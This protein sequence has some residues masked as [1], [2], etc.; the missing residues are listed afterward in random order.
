MRCWLVILVSLIVSFSAM[1]RDTLTLG[2]ED[3]AA[4][5]KQEFAEQGLGEDVELEFFGGQTSF[6]LRDVDHAKIMISGLDISEGQNKFTA[7]AE[8][9]ADGKSAGQAR[10]LGRYFVM[11]EAWLPL[12]DIEKDAV[13]TADD[14]VRTSL[15]SNRIRDDMIV[16]EE[17]LVGKQAVRTI[18]ANKPI[19]R[20][21][22][23]EEVIVKK[24][25]TVMVVYQNKG[26]QIVS[27]M[28][29]LQDGCKDQ[30]IRVLN[31]KSGKEVVGK[32]LNKNMVEIAAE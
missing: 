18:K 4:A 15:R 27:K 3:M 7:K 26:L 31:T 6:V 32:V 5:V 1:A 14:L 19:C 29:A 21:D 24:G 30:N 25:Q 16:L 2:L 20:K 28:E 22:I 12:H 8:I 13:I 17:D 10:L 23:R 11:V 9:F